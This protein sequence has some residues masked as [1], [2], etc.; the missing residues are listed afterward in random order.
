[1]MASDSTKHVVS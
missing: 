1:M